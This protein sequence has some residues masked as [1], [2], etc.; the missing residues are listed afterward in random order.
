[1]KKNFLK[2]SITTLFLILLTI[3]YLSAIGIE[4]EIFNQQIKNKVNENNKNLKINLKKIKLKLDPLRLKFNAKTVGARVLYSDKPLELEYIETDVSFAS[5]IKRKFISSN[6]EIVSRSLQLDE[7]MKFA[8]AAH[9][10]SELFILEKIVKKGHIIFNLK[11]NFDENG[12]IKDDYEIGGTIKEGK[13]QLLNNYVYEK[14]NFKFNLNKEESKFQ[15][16][17]FTTN[18]INFISENVNIKQKKDNFYIDGIIKTTDSTLSKNFL[19]VFNLNLKNFNLHNTIFSSTNNFNFEINKN[20]KLKNIFLESEIS[21]NLLK[22]KKDNYLSDYFPK[23][24]EE[25]ILKNH[26]LRLVYNENLLTVTGVGQ[27]KLEENFNKID[28]IL[29]KKDQNFN[30]QS[31]LVLESVNLKKQDFIEVF[32]P[33]VSNH[34]NIKNQKLN[35]KYKNNKL[36]LSGEGK[37]KV[38]NEFENIKYLIVT[39]DKKINFD[40]ALNLDKSDFQLNFLNY[41]KN[42][43]SSTQLKIKGYYEQDKYLFFNNLTILDDKN[44][45]KFSSLILNKNNSIKKLDYAEFDYLDTEKKLNKYSIK[46]I[47]KNNY[48]IIG[49]KF[50]ANTLITNLLKSTKNKKNN[51]LQ[52]KIFLN[53]NLDEVSLDEINYISHLKGNLFIENNNVVQ[54]NLSAAFDDNNNIS[55]SINKDADNNKITTLYSSRAKPLVKRYKFIKGFDGGYLDFYSFKKDNIS[56]SKL[57]IYEFKLKELPVLTKILTLASLQGIADIL[58]GE[59]IRFNEFEM[60]FK[61]EENFITIDEIYAIGPAISILMNGYIEQDKLISLRGTLVPATTINKTISTIPVLGKILVGDKTGE[62]V[63]GVSF[64]IKGPPKDL[65]TSVN[66]IKTLTPR[67]ITRTIEKIKKN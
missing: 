4:T 24:S 47:E 18:K 9:K 20:F 36:S 41:K 52:N 35:I 7:I 63:F 55:F 30:I 31:N 19:K 1:M 61:S 3:I 8:M 34:I 67:F 21:L 62:G 59:G 17:K 22:Y 39:K 56:K 12:K 42:N 2:F 37:I 38:D 51:F 53:I 54:A 11:I 43:Q 10:N 26:K 49:L 44:K 48:K 65:E 46:N 13:V 25:I 16:I 57:N 33:S 58:S 45:I 15:D 50:N 64:K 6:F 23:V 14:I 60:N 29:K 66:P 5:I 32:F 40:L 28:Y 27:I